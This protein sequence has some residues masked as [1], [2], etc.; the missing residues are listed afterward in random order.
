MAQEVRILA[1]DMS[2]DSAPTLVSSITC[3]SVPEDLMSSCFCRQ[4]T[5]VAYSHTCGIYAY[6]RCTH[7]INKPG[8]G[9]LQ[10]VSG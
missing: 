1:E 10:F 3:N 8:E 2:L 7:K 5:Y 6:T 4:C 9:V